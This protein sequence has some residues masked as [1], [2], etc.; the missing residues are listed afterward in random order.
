MILHAGLIAISGCGQLSVLRI[1]LCLQISDE[2]LVHVAKYCPNIVELDFYRC[3]GITD[4]GVT[5]IAGGCPRLQ[6]INLGYCTRITDGSLRSLSKCS[7]L[8]ILG[9]RGCPLVSSSGLTAI[10]LGCR[11]LA[12][13]DIRKCY[14]M[15]DAGMLLLAR[16]SQNLREWRDK[17][18]QFGVESSEVWKRKSQEML[19]FVVATSDP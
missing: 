2:G 3:T 7:D 10:A 6:S 11:K 16:V 9:I 18:L 15:N 13:L 4:M 8:N 1:A 12:E 14:S 5:A 19:A 17:T